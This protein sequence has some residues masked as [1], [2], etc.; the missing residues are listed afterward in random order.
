[1]V[2]GVGFEPTTSQFQTES[3]DQTDLPTDEK[4]GGLYWIRTNEIP[5]GALGL[6][7]LRSDQLS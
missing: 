7:A 2:C 4:Y 1:M 3:S 5:Q 6:T